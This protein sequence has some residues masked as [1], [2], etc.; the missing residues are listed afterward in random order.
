MQ[1]R[2]LSAVVAIAA[3]A[4]LPFAA[5]AAG[6]VSIKAVMTPKESIKMNFADGSKHFVL[7]VRREGVAEGQ[8]PLA[9]AEVVEYGW[10][11]IDPPHGGNPQGYLQFKISSGDIANIKWTVRAV[12]FKGAEKPVLADYG[13]WELVSGTGAFARMTGVGTL[14]ITPASETDR[15][16]TLDGELGARP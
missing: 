11:D 7:M 9:G 12:F 5:I 1:T 13:H 8:G 3:I 10:H 14:T 16:F 6:P 2:L 4:G 15:T